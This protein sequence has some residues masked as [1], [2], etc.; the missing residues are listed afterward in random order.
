MINDVI[1]RFIYEKS[2]TPASNDFGTVISIIENAKGRALKAVNAEFINISWEVGT[3]QH[4]V[5]HLIL[6]IR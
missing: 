4:Y 6:E 1:M 3:Y 5:L 2:L